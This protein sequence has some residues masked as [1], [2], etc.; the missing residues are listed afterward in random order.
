[1]ELL[2]AF[3]TI[4]GKDYILKETQF[5]KHTEVFPGWW[6]FTYI[7]LDNSSGLPP[8]VHNKHEWY[9][10][11]AVAESREDACNDMFERVNTMILD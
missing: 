9:F 2:P 1:M 11:S 5:S 7:P 8:K 6:E 10:L 4:K 3:L